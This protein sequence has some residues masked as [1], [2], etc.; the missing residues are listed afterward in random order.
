MYDDLIITQTVREKDSSARDGF[1]VRSQKTSRIND[2]QMNSL[3]LISRYRIFSWKQSYEQ[4]LYFNEDDKLETIYFI[5]PL[6]K[7]AKNYI[8]DEWHFDLVDKKHIRYTSKVE[9]QKPLRSGVRKSMV[10]VQTFQLF[11]M[12]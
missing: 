12:S 9:K 3:F 7:S 8:K 11:E 10:V 5:N 6:N 2:C 4:E 1:K